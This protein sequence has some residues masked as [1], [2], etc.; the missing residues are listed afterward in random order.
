MPG[1]GGVLLLVNN[2]DDGWIFLGLKFSIPGFFGAGK[3]GNYF[4]GDLI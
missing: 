2:G 3:F 4:L 1:G